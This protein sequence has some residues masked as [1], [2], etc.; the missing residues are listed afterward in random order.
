MCITGDEKKKRCRHGLVHTKK[1]E[2]E[3]KR[4]IVCN[5]KQKNE[6]TIR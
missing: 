1:K 6:S 2:N 5:A 3:K 4:E